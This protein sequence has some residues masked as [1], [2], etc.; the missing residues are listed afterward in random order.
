MTPLYPLSAG[1]A[2]FYRWLYRWH[3]QTGCVCPSTGYL[4]QKQGK[5]ERTIYRWLSELRSCSYIATEV[6][7][8]VARRI[9][10]LVAPA[11]AGRRRVQVQARQPEASRALIRCTEIVSLCDSAETQTDSVSGVLSGVV[12]GVLSGVLHEDAYTQETT[13]QCNHVAAARLPE[14]AEV[15]HV[16]AAPHP[17]LVE[18]LCDA[19]V[20]ASIAAGLVADRGANECREQL[21]A[22]PYRKPKDAPAVLVAAIRG[23]WAMPG[24]LVRERE[25]KALEAKKSARVQARA[26]VQARQQ[27]QQSTLLSRLSA[28]PTALYASLEARAVNLWHQEQP[29]AAKIMQGRSGAS[30]VVQ[31]YMVRILEMEGGGIHA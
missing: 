22:L 4:A 6:E 27:E 26:I 28:L 16:A 24:A 1:A 8:G 25:R 12:S 9:V 17:E 13:T 21:E 5:T 2:S 20:S 14:V 3:S 7:S 11:P 29:A 30:S 19:G 10:P 18:A 23:K 15:H 31:R